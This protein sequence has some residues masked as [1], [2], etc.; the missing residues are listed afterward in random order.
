MKQKKINAMLNALYHF[1]KQVAN[2]RRRNAL[3][4]EA[5]KVNR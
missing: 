5:R 2:R 3:A 1:K 4:K